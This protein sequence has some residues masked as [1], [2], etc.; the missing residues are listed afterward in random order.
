M[1]VEHLAVL[2]QSS[3]GRCRAVPPLMPRVPIV[4][5]MKDSASSHTH[6]GDPTALESLPEKSV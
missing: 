4:I 1:F 2:P 3:V 5:M 6:A